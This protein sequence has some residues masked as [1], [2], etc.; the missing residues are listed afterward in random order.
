V[1]GITLYRVWNIFYRILLY[2]N[3]IEKMFYKNI[4]KFTEF[5]RYMT[6]TNQLFHKTFW[7]RFRIDD[8]VFVLK[9]NKPI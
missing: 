1:I 4:I 7:K 6:H 5:L 3:H 2:I 8:F 9:Y